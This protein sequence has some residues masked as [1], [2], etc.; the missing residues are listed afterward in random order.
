M[1]KSNGEIY[2]SGD[3][4]EIGLF[5]NDPGTF[6]KITLVKDDIYKDREIKVVISPMN[7]NYT[8]WIGFSLDFLE[9]ELFRSLLI[10]FLIFIP[11]LIFII[12]VSFFTSRA[13]INPIKKL[14]QGAES[15]KLGNL[16]YR[17][18]I[19]GRDEIAQ[20]ADSFNSMTDKLVKLKLEAEAVLYSI[21][22][23]VFV[24][25]KNCKIVAFNQVAEKL[26]GYKAKEAIG[27]KYDKILKFVF[28][29]NNKINNKFIKECLNKGKITSLANHTML[30]RKDGTKIPVADSSAPL[31][32][33]N[34]INTGCVVVF[35]DI[36]LEREVDKMKTE[37]VSLASHQLRTPLTAIRLFSEMLNMGDKKGL[38]K[39]QKEYIES[40]QI[41]VERM[42]ILVNDLLNVSRLEAGKLG[43]EPEPTDLVS[44]I[45]NVIDENKALIKEK[46]CKVVFDKPEEKLPKILIDHVLMRQVINNLIINAVKYSSVKKCN[47]FVKLEEKNKKYI[48]SIKDN[49]VGI[50][51]EDQTKIFNKFF[52]SND[53]QKIE[54]SGSGLGL[55]LAY[56]IMKASGG[57]IWFESSKDKGSTFYVSFSLAG[58]KKTKGGKGLI[59]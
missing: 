50:S 41:S 24:I 40:I 59:T 16:N 22:D 27:Q 11:V 21:G 28:E 29:K 1:I 19:S 52:R 20:L 23:G 17:I 36:T 7:K 9:A 46:K 5:V 54:P 14:M 39:K 26:S 25:D 30:I 13:I 8:V 43:V 57:K 34:G 18:N 33:K 47:V 12:V 49:G 58:M 53:A 32:N 55:Y 4:N 2:L 31:K 42:I 35:R 56:M 15:I 51:K 48:I 45:Q 3:R 6:S 44:F 38:T 10:N 37:F